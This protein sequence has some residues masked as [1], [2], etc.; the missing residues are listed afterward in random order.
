MHAFG[1]TEFLSFLQNKLTHIW[2]YTYPAWSNKFKGYSLQYRDI[3]QVV[4]MLKLISQAITFKN[5]RLVP[6]FIFS[7]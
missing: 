6:Y 1:I 4:Q 7:L 2:T 3:V 5:H